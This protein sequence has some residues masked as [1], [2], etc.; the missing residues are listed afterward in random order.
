MHELHK[1]NLR[2]ANL[3]EDKQQISMKKQRSSSR[4][5]MHEDHIEE[6][7]QADV[8]MEMLNSMLQEKLFEK[9]GSIVDL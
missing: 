1:D 3:M 5:S 7:H 9:E 4:A 2:M 6:G 8:K